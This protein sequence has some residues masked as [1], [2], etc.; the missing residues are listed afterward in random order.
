LFK[1]NDNENGADIEMNDDNADGEE[2]LDDSQDGSENNKNGQGED[3]NEEEIDDEEDSQN[4]DEVFKSNALPT[5][6]EDLGYNPMSNNKGSGGNTAQQSKE[7]KQE[8]QENQNDNTN[9]DQLEELEKFQEIF[10]LNS[11][12][13]SVWKTRPNNKSNKK[14]IN[15]NVNKQNPQNPDDMINNEKLNEKEDEVKDNFDFQNMTE[16]EKEKNKDNNNNNEFDQ[17][18]ADNNTESQPKASGFNKEEDNNKKRFKEE[19]KKNEEE[20]K[21]RNVYEND[22]DINIDNNEDKK[23]NVEKENQKQKEEDIALLNRDVEEKDLE[24]DQEMEVEEDYKNDFEK[25]LKKEAKKL[26]QL[27]LEMDKDIEMEEEMEKQNTDDEVDKIE[28]LKKMEGDVIEDFNNWIKSD[29]SSF[30]VDLWNRLESLSIDHINKLIEHL[31]IA[32]EPNKQT[33][34]RGNYKSG[35]RLNI[36]KIISFIA[37]NYRNDKIW[38]RR[39]LPFERNYY[40]TLAIDDSLSM[41]EHNLGFFALESLVIVSSALNRAGIGKISICGIKEDMEVYH[42]HTEVFNREKGSYLLS[43]FKFDFSSRLSHDVAMTN[44]MKNSMVMLQNQI[45]NSQG[46]ASQIV[47]IIS[48]GRFNKDNV[49]S[50]CMEAK[51]KG[52][53]YVFIILDKYGIENNNSILNMNSVRHVY[54]P[55][56]DYDIEVKPYLDDFPFS[57]YVIVEDSADLPEVI[58]T[59]LVK[60]FTLNSN[61]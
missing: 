24:D 48:D 61:Q 28:W 33:K 46:D 17:G 32:L 12:L 50:L 16:E 9:M 40:V 55:D 56:G 13:D 25:H 10:D 22:K 38:L 59:I 36:K 27:K 26:N 3:V 60:W 1:E 29:S 45:R 52:F 19:E 35:K 8:Q 7:N 11:M 21:E 5:K 31:K 47:F 34:L 14:E 54:K 4:L 53:L 58:Q 41:K 51:E 42:S 23:M 49:R 43:K 6:N 20:V 37:S 39:T 15:R 18:Y 2:N 30:S 57:Y 44:F